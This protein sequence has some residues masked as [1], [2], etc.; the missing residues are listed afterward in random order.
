MAAGADGF[1]G[2]ANGPEQLLAVLRRLM[3]EERV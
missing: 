3:E 2:K 1:V